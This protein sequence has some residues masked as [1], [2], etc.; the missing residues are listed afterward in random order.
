MERSEIE[1]QP[2]DL[3]A[4]LDR[5]ERPFLLDVRWPQEYEVCRFD[6]SRL[7]PLDQLASSLDELDADQEI[8]V[9]CHHGV[10][11]LNAAVF[12]RQHGFEAKS[13]AGGI[14]LWSQIIDPTVPRY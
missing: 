1:I 13:L 12:L 2:Q 11:S 9:V 7:I 14:D 6:G 8:V 3:K 4:R 10:R 5:G